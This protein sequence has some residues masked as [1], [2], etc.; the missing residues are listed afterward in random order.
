MTAP[1]RNLSNFTLIKVFLFLFTMSIACY[2][3][4]GGGGGSS[5]SGT[6][7]IT[8]DW[9]AVTTKADGSP[10][11]DLG[12]YKLYYGAASGVYDHSVDVGNVTSYALTGLKQGQTYYVVVTAY[13]TSNREGRYST[14]VSKIAE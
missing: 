6:G 2:C 11:I 9:D 7:T 10:L 8:A 1:K 13:D 4:G 12:G 5:P 14:E 3:C